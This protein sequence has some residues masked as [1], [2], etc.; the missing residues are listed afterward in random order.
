MPV[1]TILTSSQLATMR[2]RVESETSVKLIYSK[3]DYYPLPSDTRLLNTLIEVPDNPPELI[4]GGSRA[5]EEAENA[6]KVFEYLGSLDRTQAADPR[7]WTTLTHTTF[8]R[9]CRKRWPA[10]KQGPAYILE[11]WFEKR[12]GGLGALRRNAISRLWWAAN[13]T[14]APWESDAELT[15]L[16]SSDRYRFTRVL[17]SQAQIFQDVIEREFGSNQRLRTLLLSS[18]ERHLPSVSNKDNL[19]KATSTQLLLVLK[20]RHVDA[21]PLAEA[22]RVIDSIVLGAA[23]RLVAA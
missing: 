15:H 16:R 4:V 10:G 20:N 12:G 2:G 5:D 21:L 22:E 3:G 13:L 11:H 9:Y 19:S 17:L 14:V 7:L 23:Q 8:W 18:L 6:I 1:Q